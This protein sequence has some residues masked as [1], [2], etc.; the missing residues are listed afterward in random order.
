MV[1]ADESPLLRCQA[2]LQMMGHHLGMI[3]VTRSGQIEME[4]PQLFNHLKC[5]QITKETSKT[6]SQTH[7]YKTINTK[8][9][10]NHNNCHNMFH[11]IQVKH[12]TRPG[13]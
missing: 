11:Q 9:Q 2:F 6:P 7:A 13:L 10:H 3:E 12:E 5:N 8:W 1:M 4:S